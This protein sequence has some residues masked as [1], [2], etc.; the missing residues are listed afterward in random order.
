MSHEPHRPVPPVGNLQLEVVGRVGHVDF[1]RD[2]PLA[3]LPGPDADH[4]VLPR[5]RAD[6]ARLDDPAERRQDLRGRVRR[7]GVEHA[8]VLQRDD[9]KRGERQSSDDLGLKV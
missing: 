1:H 3:D 7:R 9:V 6:P 4:L 8:S 5:L 2:G